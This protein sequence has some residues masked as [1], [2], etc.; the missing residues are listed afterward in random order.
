MYYYISGK[1]AYKENDFAVID[2]GGVGYKVYASRE[3]LSS[4]GDTGK[5][6]RLFTYLNFKT[7]AGTDVFDLYG[8]ATLEEKRIFEMIIGVSRIGAKTA[9]NLLS[10]ISPSKFA[11]CVAVGDSKYIAQ[12]TPGLGAKGAERIVLEL[13]DKFKN[14]DFDGIQADEVFTNE[15]PADNE[16]LSALVV[17]GYSRQ[18]AENAI[19]GASGSTEEIIK[20]GLKNL[21]KG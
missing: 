11:L 6:A 10:N 4:I 8:F 5:E 12:K 9:I 20:I 1:I 2:A 19:K 16:A 14:T 21:M 17:L 13:K 7:G 15:A 18:E 3:T